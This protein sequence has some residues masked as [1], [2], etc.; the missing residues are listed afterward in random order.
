M[1]RNVMVLILLLS[2]LNVEANQQ[3]AG[4]VKRVEQVAVTYSSSYALGADGKIIHWGGVVP[5]PVEYE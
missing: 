2:A 5:T 1:Q 4:D 3:S